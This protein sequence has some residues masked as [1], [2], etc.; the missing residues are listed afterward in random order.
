[1][2]VP[3]FSYIARK[4]R[5]RL[6]GKNRKNSPPILTIV[7]LNS[8]LFRGDLEILEERGFKVFPIPVFWQWQLVHCFYAKELTSTSDIVVRWFGRKA[9]EDTTASAFALQ[10]FLSRFLPQLYR[11]FKC[12]LLIHA[13]FRHLPDLDWLAANEKLAHPSVLLFRELLAVDKRSFDGVVNRTRLNGKSFGS[14]AV[15]GN[16]RIKEALERSGVFPPGNVVALGSLRM[17]KF[18]TT[19][20]QKENDR[21]QNRKKQFTVVMFYQP[22]RF[23]GRRMPSFVQQHD[24]TLKVFVEIAKRHPEYQII[25]K[26]KIEHLSGTKNSVKGLDFQEL[27]RHGWDSS[28]TNLYIQSAVD[29]QTLISR[30]DVVIGFL[31]T[32]VLEAAVAGKTVVVPFFEEFRLSPCSADYPLLTFLPYVDV[33]TGKEHL[34]ELIEGN[35]SR[36]VIDSALMAKRS[37]FF[38]R[39]VSPLDQG[40]CSAIENCLIRVSGCGV[41]SSAARLK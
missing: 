24:D 18:G 2:L 19:L 31:S 37:E 15:V 39:Y 16:E 5:R 26:P 40:V 1:M 21:I 38:E 34:K 10:G 14:V 17:A 27:R 35:A 29:A 9:C 6:L 4:N 25:I 8:E 13:N 3:F 7:A 41:T 28:I 23:K 22:P 12:D 33:A 20:Q 11:S 30:S 32:G 36:K